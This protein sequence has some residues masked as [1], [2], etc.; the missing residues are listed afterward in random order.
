MKKLVIA[1]TAVMLVAGLA[2]ADDPC[3]V[4]ENNTCEGALE[5]P[6][7]TTFT[8]NNCGATNDYDLPFSSC[9]GW[10]A[11]GLDL[12]YYVDLVENQELTVTASTSYDNALYLV[13]DCT[14][15]ANS[16]VAGADDDSING[17]ETLV[18][19]AADA[20]GRYYLILDA[21]TSSGISDDW[22]VTV[23]GV[24]ATQQTTFDSLKSMYR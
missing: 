12:V 15:V 6:M 20:P 22:E 10:P 19:D 4:P 13:T 3:P 18:F 11:H 24:V 5:L 23:G 16:C 9:T 7:G 8:V 21:Y 14:D 1:L 2:M 17:V